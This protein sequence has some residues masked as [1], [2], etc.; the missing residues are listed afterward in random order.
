MENTEI[1]LATIITSIVC[2]AGFA[3]VWGQDQLYKLD[4]TLFEI[5]HFPSSFTTVLT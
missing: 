2:I 4:N 3:G 5:F 1:R